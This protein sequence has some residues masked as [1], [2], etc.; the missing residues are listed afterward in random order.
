MGDKKEKNNGFKNFA[1]G[2]LILIFLWTL[3]YNSWVLQDTFNLM[4]TISCKKTSTTPI[5]GGSCC[6]TSGSDIRGIQTL[7]IASLGISLAGLGCVIGGGSDYILKHLPWLFSVV[8]IECGM[9]VWVSTVISKH[10]TETQC[11][12]DPSLKTVNNYVV[13]VSAV[14]S[15]I[16]L[17]AAQKSK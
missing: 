6:G 9:A 7:A 10:H 5:S 15:L 1:L 2:I 13:W 12:V 4:E 14:L 8:V 3:F 11:E 17:F 16:L